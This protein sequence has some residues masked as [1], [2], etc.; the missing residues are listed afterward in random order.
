MKETKQRSVTKAVSY[1]LAATITTFTLAFLF[2]GSLEIATSIGLLDFIVKFAIYYLNER[3]WTLISW[4]YKNEKSINL[5]RN[6]KESH[7][8]TSHAK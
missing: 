8:T 1:R 5:L 7:A 3:I 4:G 6:K 2:T